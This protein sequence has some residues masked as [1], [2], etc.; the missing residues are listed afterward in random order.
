MRKNNT[1]NKP[2]SIAIQT[3][4][5]E[6]FKAGIINLTFYFGALFFVLFWLFYMIKAYTGR[7]GCVLAISNQLSQ[8][9]SRELVKDLP[10]LI[11]ASRVQSEL[12]STAA[13]AL[14]GCIKQIHTIVSKEMLF[15]LP[16]TVKNEAVECSFAGVPECGSHS[17]L[18]WGHFSPERVFPVDLLPITRPA[19]LSCLWVTNEHQDQPVHAGNR[20]CIC[21]AGSWPNSQ[22]C[23]LLSKFLGGL[24]GKP[25]GNK[26]REGFIANAPLLWHFIRIIRVQ[27]SPN[28][29][30]IPRE[31][32]LGFIMWIHTSKCTNTA[33]THSASKANGNTASVW[34]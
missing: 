5:L 18:I 34:D 31:L 26:K 1:I 3:V 33:I 25:D 20:K 19:Q 16:L 30:F 14:G 23:I 21:T 4:T 10:L 15:L 17:S 8:S 13:L 11:L 32:Y 28:E 22:N 6:L 9:S 7:C 29:G 24:L 12:L 2:A 27:G